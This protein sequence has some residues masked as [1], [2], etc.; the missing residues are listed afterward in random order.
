[1]F[2]AESTGEIILKI[3]QRFGS[4]G[5]EQSLYSHAAAANQLPPRVS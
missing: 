2:T 5:Q 3:G 1:M 4:C